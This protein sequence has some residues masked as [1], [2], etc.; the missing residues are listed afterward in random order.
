M[1]PENGAFLI[2]QFFRSGT[3][4]RQTEPWRKLSQETVNPHTH[5]RPYIPELTHCRRRLFATLPSLWRRPWG[6]DSDFHHREDARQ[7]SEAGRGRNLRFTSPR[8]G[9]MG[10]LASRSQMEGWLFMQSRD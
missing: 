8:F 7:I 10:R 2:R 6:R 9:K 3:K 1:L 4:A 5:A